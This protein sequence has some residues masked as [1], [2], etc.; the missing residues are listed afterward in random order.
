MGNG[1]TCLE[2]GILISRKNYESSVYLIVFV[3]IYV[4][5]A[6]FSTIANGLIIC[7]FVLA[8]ELHGTFYKILSSLFVSDF[9]TGS[10]IFPLLATLNATFA[11][12]D[13]NVL[14][15]CEFLIHTVSFA[16]I[17]SMMAIAYDRYLRASKRQ[18]YNLYMKKT[19]G[20]VIIMVIWLFSPIAGVLSTLV[21]SKII[22]IFAI[23]TIICILVL[24]ILTLKKLKANRMQIND[25]VCARSSVSCHDRGIKRSSRLIFILI[26]AMLLSWLPCIS[27][28]M[29]SGSML[30][31]GDKYFLTAVQQ[32]PL[33]SAVTSPVL[34]FWTNRTTR[35]C[36]VALYYKFRNRKRQA[37]ENNVTA[38]SH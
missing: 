24:Y 21:Y 38:F 8:R 28:S 1:A 20:H 12:P 18:S 22:A 29:I 36:F 4:V 9:I 26:I 2:S 37:Q 10:I 11:K 33:L 17:L 25:N 5:F 23:L 32:L 30:Y 15:T 31:S 19:K 6:I 34:Y 14:I 35:R 16:S 13:C 3:Y 27:I 7:T